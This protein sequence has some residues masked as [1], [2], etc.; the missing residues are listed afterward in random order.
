MR[1]SVGIIVDEST[2]YKNIV[3]IAGFKLLDIVAGDAINVSLLE[4]KQL[5][6]N[7][8]LEIC[9][10]FKLMLRDYDSDTSAWKLFT[11]SN[12]FYLDNQGYKKYTHTF[13]DYTIFNTNDKHIGSKDGIVV[14]YNS[15][16]NG[17]TIA[18]SPVE[19]SI[20]YLV[21]LERLSTTRE[22]SGVFIN[23]FSN[24]VVRYNYCYYDDLLIADIE[25]IS[26]KQGL[27]VKQSELYSLYHTNKD[28][29]LIVLPKECRILSIQLIHLCDGLNIVFNPSI[30][31]VLSSYFVISLKDRENYI[32]VNLNFS[33]NT[34][35]KI[36]NDIAHYLE[37]DAS[38]L[39]GDDDS[40]VKFLVNYY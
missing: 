16:L 7:N 6:E 30:E 38:S 35:K 11:V 34:D 37:R 40:K 39:Y 23:L 2:E 17:F 1:Y 19:D 25:K 28:G 4:A 10:D 14:I 26:E 5:L 9:S 32:K 8:E 24:K 12:V 13:T 3:D 18:Y 22:W 15:G 29:N 27:F 36:V 21:N 33:S 31:R 20:L